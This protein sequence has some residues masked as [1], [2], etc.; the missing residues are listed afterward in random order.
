MRVGPDVG[1]ARGGADGEV[2]VEPDAEAGAAPPLGGRAELP[3]EL[4]L[5]PAVEVHLPGMGAA[6]RRHLG[7]ARVAVLP[8]PA[9]PIVLPQVIDQRLEGGEAVERLS[10]GLEVPPVRLARLG[11]REERLE[12][13]PLESHHPLV[14]HRAGGAECLPL[15]PD[16][17]RVEQPPVTRPRPGH[18]G[19]IEVDRVAVEAAHRTVRAHVP[20]PVADRV[21]RVHPDEGAA[22]GRRPLEQRGEARQ[23]TD[24]PILPGP[25]GVEIGDDAEHRRHRPAAAGRHDE[26]L[27]S[28]ALPSARGQ[29]D[30]ERVVPV[31]QPPAERDPSGAGVVQLHGALER[32]PLARF[33]AQRRL[34]RHG[35]ARRRR[36]PQIGAGR[37]PP[38]ADAHP[39]R[40]HDL[41]PLARVERLQRVADA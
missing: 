11:A 36:Q 40:R 38:L 29:P 22:L 34:P 23:V 18:G 6:E 21:Q 5:E 13:P 3:V 4:V 41:G 32:P 10:F 7:G 8:G 1:A 15:A 16:L 28:F 25:H 39:H 27:L 33:Q 12:H 2:L 35:A 30:L 17:R 24:T 26:R 20:A 31:G 19:G 14:F 9:A 37:L